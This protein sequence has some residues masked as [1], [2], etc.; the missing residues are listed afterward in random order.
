[1]LICLL[2]VQY[3]VCALLTFS[4]YIQFYSHLYM[5]VCNENLS[6]AHVHTVHLINKLA[7][8][9]NNT[10]TTVIIFQHICMALRHL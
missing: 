10:N 3:M 9:C 2:N 1:M 5:C 7:L 6:K 4:I 8:R